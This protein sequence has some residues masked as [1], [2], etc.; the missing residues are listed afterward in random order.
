[1]L[2]IIKRE[3]FYEYE[4]ITAK[5][6]NDDKIE[7]VKVRTRPEWNNRVVDITIYFKSGRTATYDSTLSNH[8]MPTKYRNYITKIMKEVK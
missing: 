2:K 5:I 1:M 8:R 3:A 4:L 6:E 7:S